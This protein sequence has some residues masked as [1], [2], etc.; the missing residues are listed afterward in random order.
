MQLHFGNYCPSLGLGWHW[1]S[2]S[3]LFATD[4]EVV[5][6]LVMMIVTAPFEPN[7]FETSA[8]E[9][10]DSPVI[11]GD[12]RGQS[13][14]IHSLDVASYG[15]EE[16]H[17]ANAVDPQLHRR[18][19]P[20][21][22]GAFMMATGLGRAVG[23]R[24]ARWTSAALEIDVLHH[25]TLLQLYVVLRTHQPTSVSAGVQAKTE[26]RQLATA[27]C[28]ACL[29]ATSQTVADT[30]GTRLQYTATSPACIY[31]ITDNIFLNERLL[32]DVR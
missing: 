32:I 16:A 26:A 7:A 31:E 2:V 27:H 20:L 1:Y 13:V 18:V 8:S 5:A 22:M 30:Q 11:V 9:A 17:K 28:L 25:G 4:A 29:H 23:I 10:N 3:V 14:A 6:A 21:I 24:R 15:L 19:A 12:P